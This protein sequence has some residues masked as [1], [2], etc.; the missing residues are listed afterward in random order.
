MP[1]MWAFIVIV[2]GILVVTYRHRN[3]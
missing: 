3:R 1:E 2:T